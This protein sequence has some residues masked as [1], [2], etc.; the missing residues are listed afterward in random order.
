MALDSCIPA[1]MTAFSVWR[2]LC[3]TTR[4]P[5]WERANALLLT[6]RRCVRKKTSPKGTTE[7]HS[8]KSKRRSHATA[9]RRN[10]QRI[11][12]WLIL[13]KHGS[14]NSR[15]TA[16]VLGLAAEIEREFISARA[17]HGT[18]TQDGKRWARGG[19]AERQCRVLM[20]FALFIHPAQFAEYR[21]CALLPYF[22]LSAEP[23]HDSALRT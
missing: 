1:G 4:A 3:I 16:V 19:W 15:I 21:Y 20:E 17:H 2:D 9:Q 8:V 14:L 5:V 18:R 11:K 10:V 6:L 23:I 13:V 22:H 12:T 7:P